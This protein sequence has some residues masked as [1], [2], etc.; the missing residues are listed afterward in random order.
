[1]ETKRN[2]LFSGSLG[3]VP[4]DGGRRG[5]SPGTPTCSRVPTL[6]GPLARRLDEATP[7]AQVAM[8]RRRWVLLR[9]GS[10]LQGQEA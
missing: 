10:W 1:M 9:V 4:S 6:G 7:S 5:F 8:G 2:I 3:R